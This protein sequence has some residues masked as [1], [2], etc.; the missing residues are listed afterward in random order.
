MELRQLRYFLTAAKLGNLS[1]AADKLNV[2]HPALGQQIKKLEEELST[3]VFERHSRGVSLT[4]AGRHL[5]DHAES[6]LQRVSIVKAQMERFSTGLADSVSI[7]VTPSLGRVLVPTLLE[8]CATRFP[9]MRLNFVQG[10]ADHLERMIDEGELD[11]AFVHSRIDSA[12]LESVPLIVE[13]LCLIGTPSMI[14]HLPDP[15]DIGDLLTLP[16]ILDQKGQL[17]RRVLEKV[18]GGAPSALDAAI[19]VQAINIR[20]EFV[21]QGKRCALAPVALFSDEILESKLSFRRVDLPEFTRTLG[22]ATPRI[23]S[24]SPS[25]AAVRMVAI[26]VVERFVSEGKFGWRP[27]LTD[28]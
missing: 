8:E 26:E 9:E 11:V 7:G 14:N 25:L 2:T 3:R 10:Y 20:R 21:M 15:I 19:E 24:I 16:L 6:I 17:T 4:P 1:A 13:S 22:L 28:W 5:V 18:I 12:T 27:A 23:E